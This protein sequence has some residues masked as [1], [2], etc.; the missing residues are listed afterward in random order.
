MTGLKLTVPESPES[1]RQLAVASFGGAAAQWA[2]KGDMRATLMGSKKLRS[3]DDYGHLVNVYEE[4]GAGL[5]YLLDAWAVPTTALHG[6]VGELALQVGNTVLLFCMLRMLHVAGVA[7]C[8]WA[9]SFLL[10]FT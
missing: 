1:A 7:C 6:A 4:A 2:L 5:E 9:V 8:Q 3:Q 10:V